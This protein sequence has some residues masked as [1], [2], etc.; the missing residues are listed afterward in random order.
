MEAS[1][2]STGEVTIVTIQGALEIEQ[3]QPFREAC[4]KY[5][6]SKKVIFNMEGASFVGS[7]GLQAFMDTVKTL[8][9]E[10]VHGLKIVCV[11]SEFRRLLSNIESEKLQ[12]FE[13]EAIAV[14]SFHLP[15]HG[16]VG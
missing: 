7:T 11:K 16:M 15:R 13:N 9:E 6:R 12:I 4:L 14:Q 8:T 1:V 3:T 2:K 10:N 5:F